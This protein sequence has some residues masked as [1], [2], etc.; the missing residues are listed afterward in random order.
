MKKKTII[1]LVIVAALIVAAGVGLNKLHK[2]LSE[3]SDFGE[4][5]PV[6]PQQILRNGRLADLPASVTDIK[7]EGWDGIFTGED[8][9][10]FRADPDDIKL[11]I[12]NSD[13]IKSQKPKILSEDSSHTRKSSY[14]PQWY[15][16][17]TI[18]KG[19]KFEIPAANHH[20]WGT[21]IIDDQTNTVY[22]EVTWS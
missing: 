3:G 16:P 1:I 4:L 15:N 21:V 12:S 19:R 22:I 2:A 8:Y 17:S 13:S 20:N 7:A 11:F 5:H 10:M 6:N 14:M 18:V 9:L